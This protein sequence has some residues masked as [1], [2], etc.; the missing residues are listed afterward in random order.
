MSSRHQ[1]A[2]SLSRR[3]RCQRKAPISK[4]RQS[5]RPEQMPRVSTYCKPKL[6]QQQCTPKGVRSPASYQDLELFP[7][8][9][10]R[11]LRRNSIVTCP[12]PL[13]QMMERTRTRYLLTPKLNAKLCCRVAA[14]AVLA[15]K[16]TNSKWSR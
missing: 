8:L 15:C 13:S 14:V 1:A 4:M 16:S 11:R 12:L 9:D 7:R 2:T 6:Q 10:T 3:S 5:G